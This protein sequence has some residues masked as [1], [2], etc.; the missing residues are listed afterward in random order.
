MISVKTQLTTR[1]LPLMQHLIIVA[2]RMTIL[3]VSF[4][5]P[6]PPHRVDPLATLCFDSN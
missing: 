3:E 4:H 6:H 5:K 1:M 2:I